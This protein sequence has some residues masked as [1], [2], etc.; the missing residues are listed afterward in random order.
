MID[1]EN[2]DSIFASIFSHA[3][4]ENYCNFTMFYW[5]GVDT[6]ESLM[7]SGSSSESTGLQVQKRLRSPYAITC[8]YRE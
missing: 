2:F 6:E 1:V 7:L 8:K 3:G 4:N 5:V